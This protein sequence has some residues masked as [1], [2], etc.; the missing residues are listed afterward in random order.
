MVGELPFPT[1]ITSE[2]APQSVAF[3]DVRN[4]CRISQAFLQ[5]PFHL[6]VGFFTKLSKTR[7]TIYSALFQFRMYLLHILDRSADA[8]IIRQ[9]KMLYPDIT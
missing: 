1:D 6:P 8:L 3:S 9:V 2:I 7:T 4:D 5:K